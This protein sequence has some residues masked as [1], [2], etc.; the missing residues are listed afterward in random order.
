[1]V[2]DGLHLPSQSSNWQPHEMMPPQLVS[3]ISTLPLLCCSHI[4]MYSLSL[5]SSLAP[6][7]PSPTAE[8]VRVRLGLGL[9]VGVAVGVWGRGYWSAW[10]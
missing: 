6:S 5:G 4:S 9:G 7:F 1:M 10:G 3:N 2:Q 8:L